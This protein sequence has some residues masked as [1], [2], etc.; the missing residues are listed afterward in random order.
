MWQTRCSVRSRSRSLPWGGYTEG[1]TPLFRPALIGIRDTVLTRAR[2]A[3]RRQAAHG[4]VIDRLTVALESSRAQSIGV[5]YHLAAHEATDGRPIVFDVS[6]CPLPIHHFACSWADLR[7]VPRSEYDSVVV[8]RP[9]DRVPW[10]HRT[11]SFELRWSETAYGTRPSPSMLVLPD[12]LPR[13]V[14]EPPVGVAA[15]SPRLALER[16]SRVVGWIA[17]SSSDVCG[18]SAELL[19]AVALREAAELAEEAQGLVVSPSIRAS[20]PRPQSAAL[21]EVTGDA[22][23]VI[24]AVLGV[25]LTGALVLA[26]PRDVHG[27]TSMPA[28]C[29]IV[30]DG[31][32]AARDRLTFGIARRVGSV[33]W[34]GACKIAGRGG[35]EYEFAI[36][37]ALALQ[38]VRELC[39]PTKWTRERD[40]LYAMAGPRHRMLDRL[41]RARGLPS[42]AHV[43]RSAL[44]I[45]EVLSGRQ[46]AGREFRAITQAAW[47]RILDPTHLDALF[48][49]V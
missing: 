30:A 1:G 31:Y 22:R 42:I 14:S 25:P 47:G 34:G 12:W 15:G 4:I 33:W 36:A 7:V 8:V 28:G 17:A 29:L 26:A 24:T 2:S 37:S 43:A 48:G 10:Q 46:S 19:Q 11:L 9:H 38:V 44:K 6:H 13:L 16:G 20:W 18:A 27:A 40:R 3:L 45:D 49:P 5:D 23:A 41:R 39:G 21:A 32:D 35:E